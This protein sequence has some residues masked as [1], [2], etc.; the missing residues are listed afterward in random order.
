MNNAHTYPSI[1]HKLLFAEHAI[2]PDQDW[3]LYF[4]EL[5]VLRLSDGAYLAVVGHCLLDA[6]GRISESS[7]I[8][9]SLVLTDDEYVKVV[10]LRTT[11]DD[12]L[13]TA[14]LLNFILGHPSLVEHPRKIE[15]RSES[16]S[17]PERVSVA[18]RR[19]QGEAYAAGYRSEVNFDDTWS[20]F[21]KELDG[22]RTHFSCWTYPT[23][24]A[25]WEAATSQYLVMV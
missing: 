5:Q 12:I 15:D 21:L 7:S 11:R 20:F 6:A 13:A 23:E 8:T 2:E 16:E 19:W 18:L 22:S 10:N 14:A 24:T 25:A 4:P 3:L 9:H 17:W 1:H